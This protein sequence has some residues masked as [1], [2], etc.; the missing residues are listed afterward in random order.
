MSIIIRA[1]TGTE[2]STWVA[3]GDNSTISVSTN[4]SSWTTYQLSD[5][6]DTSL[7]NVAYGKDTATGATMWMLATNL[8]YVASSSNPGSGAVTWSGL[9]RITNKSGRKGFLYGDNGTGVWVMCARA[10]VKRNFSGSWSG[11]IDL[12]MGRGQSTISDGTGTWGLASTVYNTGRPSIWKSLDDGASWDEAWNWPVNYGVN[13]GSNKEY[14]IAYK[15]NKWVAVFPEAGIFT[16]SIGPGAF[17]SNSFS[18]VY[19]Y[20]GNMQYVEAGAANTWMAVDSARNVYLSTDDAANWS[21]VTSIPGSD[22]PTGMAYDTGTWVVVTDGT[23]NNI[24]KS[25]DNGNSWTAVASTGE[26]V[27][28]I[29]VSKILP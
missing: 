8:A 9:T 6:T 15:S 14:S 5:T 23:S 29:A 3:V 28:K 7:V 27:R 19:T 4:L 26:S 18:R 16:G 20:S 24:V 2:E 25:T 10:R 17:D 13:Y 1:G 22:A 11:N 21:S 12:T